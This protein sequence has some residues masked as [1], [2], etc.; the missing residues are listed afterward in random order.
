MNQSKFSA[1]LHGI[2]PALLPIIALKPAI[3][4]QV[5]K[6]KKPA[7]MQVK[8]AP[9]LEQKGQNNNELKTNFD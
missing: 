5:N 4:N 3:K 8:N 7:R 6:V 1:N 9:I 2:W